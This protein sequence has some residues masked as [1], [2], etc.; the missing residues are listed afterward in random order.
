L[1]KLKIYAII[2]NVIKRDYRKILFKR[3]KKM[4]IVY[5]R[6]DDGREWD[7]CY[8]CFN[9]ALLCFDKISTGCVEGFIMNDLTGEL[10]RTVG[11]EY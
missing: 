5:V 2:L 7:S 8:N 9:N 10:Y 4:Y 11:C 6:F 3:G 1:T